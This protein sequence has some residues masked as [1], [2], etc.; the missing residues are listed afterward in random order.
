M[1]GGG[2]GGGDHDLGGEGGVVDAHVEFEELVLGFAGD[3]FAGEVHAV[4]HVEEGIDVFHLEDVGFVMGEIVVLFDTAGDLGEV[5]SGFKL[6]VDHAAVDAGAG[7]DG[8]GE[9][10]AYAFDGF[11]GDGVAH[12]HAGTE[13]GVGDAFR[14]ACLEEGTD[15]GVGAG[16]PAGGH[17]GDGVVAEGGFAEGAAEGDGAGVDVETV[18]G[19]YAEGEGFEGVSLDAA[20]GGAEDGDLG[21][22]QFGEVAHDFIGGGF[23]GSLG[24]IA[25]DDAGDFEVGRGL[26]RFQDVVS[27][28]AVADDGGF[29]FFHRDNYFN[30]ANLGI[31]WERAKGFGGVL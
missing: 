26:K 1:P 3:A 6:D 20:G 16:V 5:L 19:V 2:T 21:A 23:G 18:H 14:G 7:G 4:P 29:D 25:A 28:V 31:I 9:D 17:D 8:H 11:D 13:V 22:G 30:Q 12:A 15:D 24:G 10:C 27:D